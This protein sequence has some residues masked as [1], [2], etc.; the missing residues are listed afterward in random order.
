LGPDGSLAAG[1][2]SVATFNFR[3]SVEPLVYFK[4][5]RAL[6]HYR[7]DDTRDSVA[8]GKQGQSWGR[9]VLYQ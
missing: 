7:G 2:P 1:H 8:G 5:R 6:Q 3:Q 4:G 9:A